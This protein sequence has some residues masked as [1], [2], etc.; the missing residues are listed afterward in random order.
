M[1]PFKTKWSEVNIFLLHDEN[2]Y[3][4]VFK[5]NFDVK[6]VVEGHYQ[7]KWLMCLEFRKTS[8]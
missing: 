5:I 4:K 8:T 1:F 6:L 7:E 2:F 3:L